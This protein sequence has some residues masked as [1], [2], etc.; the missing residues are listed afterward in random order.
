MVG[1]IRLAR[2][3]LAELEVRLLVFGWCAVAFVEHLEAALAP[4]SCRCMQV[5]AVP[6]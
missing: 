4:N 1:Y 2:A 5:P 3:E 6:H